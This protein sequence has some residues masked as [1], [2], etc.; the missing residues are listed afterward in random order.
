M[1]TDEITGKKQSCIQWGVDDFMVKFC[2]N[3]HF[4]NYINSYHT[5]YLARLCSRFFCVLE[6]FRRKFVNLVAPRTNG[7]T[8]RLVRCKVHSVP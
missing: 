7:T 2:Q 8:K 6:N 1:A 4:N 3:V 5:K